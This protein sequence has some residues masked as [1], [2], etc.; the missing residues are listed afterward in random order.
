MKRLLGILITTGIVSVPIVTGAATGPAKTATTATATGANDTAD[1]QKLETRLENARLVLEQIEGVRDRAIPDAIASRARCVAVVPGLVKGAFI[2]GAEYGQGVATC[3]TEHGWSGPVFIRMAGGSFG[4]QVGG[5]GTDLVL[6][7]VNHRGM[8]N[9]LQSQFKIGASASAAA[10]P[11]GRDT[12]AATDISMRAQLLT[13][14][15][16]R[17]IFAGVD[18]NGV[19]VSQNALDTS[20]LYGRFHNFDTILQGEVPPPPASHAFLQTVTHYFGSARADEQ[21]KHDEEQEH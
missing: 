13:W 8:L 20:T 21:E 16:A 18:L 17:G 12:Q 5:K 1:T 14:S 19:M 11:V 10:G 9:L 6:V 2:I 4:F 15:R 7:A 3:R